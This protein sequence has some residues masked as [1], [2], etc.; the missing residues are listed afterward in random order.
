MVSHRGEVACVVTTA[1]PLDKATEKEL[2]T[3]LEQF[4][5][6]GQ[7]LNLSLKVGSAEP[8]LVFSV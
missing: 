8:L 3:A 2:S 5:E 4:L 1:K 7:K 6:K